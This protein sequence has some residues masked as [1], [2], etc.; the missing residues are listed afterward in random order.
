[1]QK[2]NWNDLLVYEILIFKL[3]LVCKFQNIL[4]A[5]SFEVKYSKL[6][7]NLLLV[8]EMLIFK[9]I[10]VCKFQNVPCALGSEVRHSKFFCFRTCIINGT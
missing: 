1:M 5:L 4:C 9:L 8:S 6:E 10:L 2:L 3:I 7:F